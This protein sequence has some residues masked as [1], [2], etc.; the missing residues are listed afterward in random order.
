M[1]TTMQAMHITTALANTQK[2]VCENPSN[3][4]MQIT[5]TMEA[6]MLILIVRNAASGADSHQM[7]TRNT[8]GSMVLR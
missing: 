7:W 1:N 8:E 3:T 5:A 4:H 6:Q 2:Y